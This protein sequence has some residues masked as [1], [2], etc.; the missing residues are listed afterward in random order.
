MSNEVTLVFTT[1]PNH[2]KRWEYFMRCIPRVL[3]DVTASRHDIIYKCISES[4]RD[5]KHNWYGL[6]LE[7]FCNRR[8]ISLK[9]R[10][11]A[12]SLGGMMNDAGNAI[13]TNYGMIIQDDWFLEEP[14][15]LSPGIEFMEENKN[16]DIL[17]YSW[18]V[19]MTEPNGEFNGYRTLASKGPWP[20]GDDPHLRRKTFFQRFGPYNM[21][22]R[23]GASESDMVFRFGARNAFVCIT[24]KCYF[25]HCGEVSAVVDDE[26]KRAVKR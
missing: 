16:V 9:F 12:A 17:R 22:K 14:F 21:D 20:Y 25:G 5:P 3:K 6:H 10:T 4:E 19:G 7:E 23:H 13:E 1:W 24:D 18:P 15:D 8:N 26:R 2:P 11:A